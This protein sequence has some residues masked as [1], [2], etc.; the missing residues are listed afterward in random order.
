MDDFITKPIEPQPLLT[1][2]AKWLAQRPD[3]VVPVPAATSF[4][5]SVAVETTEVAGINDPSIIDLSILSEVLGNQPDKIRKYVMMFLDLTQKAIIEIEVALAHGD[6][7]TLSDLG[8]RTK[9]SARTVGAM[10]FGE[11][12]Q[13][14]EQLKDGGDTEQA[15]DIAVQMQTLLVQI[16][17]SIN[18]KFV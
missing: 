10:G 5:E 1:T 18:K 11:L 2:L 13:A 15:R 12:C 6:M 4:L 7:A 8:H 14:L 3:R 16:S 17:E 9:S